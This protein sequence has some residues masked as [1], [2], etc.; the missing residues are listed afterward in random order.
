MFPGD[1]DRVIRDTQA[2]PEFRRNGI[3]DYLDTTVHQ[4]GLPISRRIEK[5]SELAALSRRYHSLAAITGTD[6][7]KDVAEAEIGE[8]RYAEIDGVKLKVPDLR[9]IFD[10]WRIRSIWP[11]LKGIPDQPL[12]V[13]IGA[14]YGGLALKLKR[15]FPNAKIALFDLPEVNAIQ[16]YYLRTAM[17]TAQLMGTNEFAQGDPMALLASKWDFLIL[18][19]WY[20]AEFPEKSVNLCINARSLMEMRRDVVTYYIRELKRLIPSGGA[21]YCVN[22]YIKSTVGEAVRLK[23]YAF[24]D[25]WS[26]RI[27]EPAWDQPWIH[28]LLLVRLKHANA[29][30]IRELLSN[31]P[32]HS[33]KDVFAH[34][35]I[36]A[37]M[38][39]HLLW[40]AN[41]NVNPGL[42][43]TIV[44]ARK[45]TERSLVRAIR[46]FPL[47]HRFLRQLWG[48]RN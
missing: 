32:P 14:G 38:V 13:E 34:L 25:N 17:P 8:P 36:A 20:I 15:L 40:G 46:K 31:L 48:S 24:D 22:R 3:S 27:S 11:T 28:E 43:G 2:W 45:R 37:K 42:R 41:P 18:P 6:F 9:H 23:D 10:A 33:W 47:L 7:I 5:S 4:T 21:F 26:M 1:Y 29:I 30:S 39:A 12:I 35:S 44:N 19:G 16:A